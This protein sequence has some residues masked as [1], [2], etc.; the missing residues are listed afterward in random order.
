M[1]IHIRAK[2]GR[3][4]R[5]RQDMALHNIAL[6]SNRRSGYTFSEYD[7]EIGVVC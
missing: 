5:A 3:A 2:E 6:L 4:G 1:I 7:G